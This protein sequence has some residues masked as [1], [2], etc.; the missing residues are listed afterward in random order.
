MEADEP[1]ITREFVTNAMR[2]VGPLVPC[3]WPLSP[4]ETARARSM[5]R[6]VGVDRLTVAPDGQGSWTFK[7]DGDFSGLVLGHNG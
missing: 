6:L 3:T 5:L 1:E 2:G 4:E 7:G